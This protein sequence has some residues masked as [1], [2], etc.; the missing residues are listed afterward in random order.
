MNHLYTSSKDNDNLYNQGDECFIHDGHCSET[1]PYNAIL[2][3]YRCDKTFP[4]TILHIFNITKIR[5]FDSWDI[6][7]KSK[8]LE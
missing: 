3:H 4:F 1:K 6:I 8:E 5:I 2:F 7:S